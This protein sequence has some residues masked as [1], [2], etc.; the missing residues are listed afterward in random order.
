MDIFTT[1]LTRFVPV[2]IKPTTLKVKALLK[3]AASAK[4]KEDPDHLE[5]HN[6]Y[7]LQSDKKNDRYYSGEQKH[8][9]S[10]KE[11]KALSDQQELQEVST[12]VETKIKNN[13]PTIDDKK[14][15]NKDKHLDLY[16]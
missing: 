3:D 14:T 1:Q 7:F 6:H 2:P 15:D 8:S 16:A 13:K 10:G 12:K 9:E 5:D 11:E 4:L